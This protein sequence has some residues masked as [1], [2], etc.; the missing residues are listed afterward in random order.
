MLGVSV[1]LRLKGKLSKVLDRYLS[2]NPLDYRQVIAIIIPLF[3]DQLFY[4]ILALS[5]TAMIS[6][7]G[8]SAIAAVSMVDSI[9]VV[10]LNIFVALATGGTVIVAQY[11]G[12]G[13]AELVSKAAAHAVA[14]VLMV[15]FTVSILLVGFHNPILTF[16]FKSAEQDV[17][18]NAKLYIIGSGISYPLVA[19][20]D[21]V[22]GVLR[23]VGNT[24]ASLWLSLIKN[25]TYLIFNFVFL[26]ILNMGIVGL[27]ISM[28]L[29]RFL[30]MLC[31]VF[32]IT[33]IHKKIVLR[34]KDMINIDAKM[35]KRIMFIGIP[36]ATEQ[37][38]FNGGKLVTQTFIVKLGTSAI[39]INAI[40]T[41]LLYLL[42]IGGLTFSLA[43][44]TVVGLC[45]GNSQFKDARKYVR[46]FLIL[47][48]L[49]TVV[50]GLILLPFLPSL[51]GV[52]SPDPQ[53][54]PTIK[55]I[56][57]I[58]WVVTP[59]FWCTSFVSPAALRAAGDA[60]FALL[61]SLSCMWTLR[62]ILGY[63]LGVVLNLGILGIWIS[64]YVEWVLRGV[65]FLIRL[66]GKKWLS[67]KLLD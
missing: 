25:G 3:I 27:I 7:S 55:L 29:S 50:I 64:M 39:A 34:F 51:I 8:Q 43:V 31:S 26:S 38:F 4:G 53:I 58:S 6:S 17:F 40:C 35:L 60:R 46:I 2:G 37:V 21:A 11:Q 44:V 10:L 16:L 65:I 49:S 19:S 54:V 23:G 56:C 22:C 61:V 13:K 66:R 45:V 18:S 48:S 59:L 33:L 63:V 42:E 47:G 36:I 24:K 67:H 5:N 32:Y 62:V 28:V 57:Y 12:A 20:I 52:Y 1:L 30:G 9:N 14:T 41:S 15:S